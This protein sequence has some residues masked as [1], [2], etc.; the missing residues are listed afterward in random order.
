[1]LYILT[2]G[3]DDTTDVPQIKGLIEKVMDGVGLMEIT[4][5]NVEIMGFP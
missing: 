5:G 2:D 1:M 4:G 3:N